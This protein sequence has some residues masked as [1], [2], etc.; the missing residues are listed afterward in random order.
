MLNPDI[1][2]PCNFDIKRVENFDVDPFY[3]LMNKG[4]ALS[5]I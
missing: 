1:L 3:I 4:V 5:V 2:I